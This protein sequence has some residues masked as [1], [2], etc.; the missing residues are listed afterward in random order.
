MFDKGLFFKGPLVNRYESACFQRLSYDSSI[1]FCPDFLFRNKVESF[2]VLINKLPGIL[3]RLDYRV[4]S[5]VRMRI[6]ECNYVNTN[7][8]TNCFK[9]PA[10]L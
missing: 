1:P 7:I 3:Y 9:L 10:L 5:N 4:H 6:M 8:G 2:I